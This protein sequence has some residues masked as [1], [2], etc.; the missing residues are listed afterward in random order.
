LYE[1][2][3]VLRL[4]SIEERCDFRVSGDNRRDQAGATAVEAANEVDIYL[5]AVTTLEVPAGSEAM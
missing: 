1:L 2:T 3:L 4:T 5:G